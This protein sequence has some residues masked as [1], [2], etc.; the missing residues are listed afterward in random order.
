MKRLLSG[1]FALALVLG[2]SA[3][4]PQNTAQNAQNA[5]AAN[6]DFST[7]FPVLL[8]GKTVRVQIAITDLETSNGLMGRKV[9][10]PDEGMLFVFAETRR[11]EFWMRDV[12]INLALGY[13]TADGRL[14]EIKALL[15]EDPNTVPSR[16]EGIRFVLEM[17]EGWFEDNGVKPGTVLD[18]GAV[19]AAVKARGFPP[20]RFG[21]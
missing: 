9:L 6:A 1:L 12:P 2:F 10:A 7:R 15:S 20:E 18:L 8:G 16:S 19:K 21:L 11:R 13:L 17:R 14:D 5:V 3:C 4:K